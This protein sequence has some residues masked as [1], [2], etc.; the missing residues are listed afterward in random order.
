MYRAL[1]RFICTNVMTSVQIIDTS[2]TSTIE[3]VTNQVSDIAL[4]NLPITNFPAESIDMVTM[5]PVVASCHSLASRGALTMADLTKETQIVL[6]DLGGSVS[7]MGEDDKDVGWLKA[8]RRVTVDNF[9]LAME[10]VKS[11][12]G[13]TR[14]PQYMY[15]A[16]EDGEL[17]QLEIKGANYYQVPIHITLPKGADTGPAAVNLYKLIL[18]ESKS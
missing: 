9:D 1:S 6:R 14:I 5:V 7:N 2:L 17:V 15:D 16:S 13:F 18:E 12:L 10:A 8:K 4:I 11:G 3:S